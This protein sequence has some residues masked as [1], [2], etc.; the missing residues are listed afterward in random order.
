MRFTTLFTTVVTVSTTANALSFTE[1]FGAIKRDLIKRVVTPA[2][3]A[4]PSGPGSGGSG[5]GGG[6][7]SGSGSGGSGS[8]GGGGGQGGGIFSPLPLNIRECAAYRM[9]LTDL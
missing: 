5:S 8:E 4:P 7:G 1:S 3:V 2:V 9:K 6:G